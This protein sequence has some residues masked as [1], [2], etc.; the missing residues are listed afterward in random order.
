MA[1]LDKLGDF[2]RNIGDKANDVIEVTKLNSKISSEK[3]AITECMWRIGEYYYKK[4]QAGEADDSGAAELYAVID[5]HNKTIA[6]I[7]AEIARIQAESAAQAQAA[8][9]NQATFAIPLAAP[10]AKGITCPSC[11]KVNMPGTKFCFE[12]GCKL[13]IPAAPTERPCPDCGAQVPATN[14]FCVK[15]GYKFE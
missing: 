3:N 5:G 6:D 11:G 4:H 10:V 12:C 14:K 8:Q 7:Q 15:C 13:E 1:F 9:S 2:A